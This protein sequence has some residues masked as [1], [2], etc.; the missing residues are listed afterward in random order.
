VTRGRRACNSEQR[1]RDAQIFDAPGRSKPTR[2][3]PRL[4]PAQSIFSSQEKK[5][6]V[7]FVQAF[8]IVS[9]TPLRHSLSVEQAVESGR[10]GW[11]LFARQLEPDSQ[12]AA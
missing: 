5:H 2:F 11:Q 8:V 7:V 4:A 10:R 9:Q 6:S 3:A 1:Y 12:V